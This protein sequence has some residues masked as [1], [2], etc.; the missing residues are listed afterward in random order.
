MSE[1]KYIIII[2]LLAIFSIQGFSQTIDKAKLAEFEEAITRGEEYLKSKDY[3]KAK[4]EY[5]K[6]LSIDPQAKY[7]K[8]K[9]AQIRKVYTDP[10][11]E[12]NF[13][14]AVKKADQYADIKQ[15]DKAKEHY[16][17]ALTIKPDDRTV[18][19]KLSKTEQLANESNTNRKDYSNAIADADNLYTQK[20]Y[21]EA[22]QKY[23]LAANILPEETYPITK[24][25]QIETLLSQEKALNEKYNN[26]LAEADEAY[27]NRDYKTAKLKYEEA[28]RIKPQENYATTMLER[29]KESSE[30][31][32]LTQA[33]SAKQLNEQYNSTIALGDQMFKENRYNEA[34]VSYNEAAKLKPEEIYPKQKIDQ[35]NASI[36]KE[37]DERKAEIAKQERIQREKE[38][39][40]IEQSEREAQL[41][42]QRISDELEAAANKQKAD[43]EKRIKEIEANN[44]AQRQK[45]EEENLLAAAEAAKENERKALLETQK[46]AEYQK[47][48]ERLAEMEA[49]SERS[50]SEYEAAIENGN[51]FYA[52]RDY[53]SALKMFEEASLLKPSEKYPKERIIQINNI[54]LE[55]LRNNVESYNKFIS[56]ADRAFQEN[57]FDKAL[58]EFEKALA[59][60]PEEAYPSIMITRIKKI[61]EDNKI[62]GIVSNTITVNDAVEKKYSFT[63][64]DMNQRKNNYLLIK[65]KKASEKAPT[66]FVSY[67]KDSMKSGGFVL[68]GIES[69]EPTEYIFRIST[70]DKWYRVDNNWISIYPEGGDIEITGMQISQG[71]IKGLK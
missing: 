30:K 63:A 13:S 23:R 34:L 7:P 54:L 38:A 51:Q 26:T 50:R 59:S 68:K 61:M 66:I 9:L 45:E 56:S 43:E 28:S 70:Q 37:D 46:Q 35:I 36:Q 19:D 29:V 52:L 71:D 32:A 60:R 10:K 58:E 24:I 65:A 16:N 62:V 2:S 31:F 18:K 20:K 25:D 17:I 53:P 33:E 48:M 1:L 49:A 41:E 21:N 55:R 57:A 12:A 67:G 11:D 27:M 5:Q 4:A 64:I 8:D 44:L 39:L 22:L 3:A 6:A 14:E 47:E 15:Y 69:E 42:A 40:A